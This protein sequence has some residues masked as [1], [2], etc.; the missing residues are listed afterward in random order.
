MAY[1]QALDSQVGGHV[2]VMTTED[3][4]LLIK[5]A[6]RRE[7]EFYH[8]MHQDP[9]LSFLREFTPKFIG[10]LRLEGQLSDLAGENGEGGL[11]IASLSEGIIRPAEGPKDMCSLC[12]GYSSVSV[13]TL[14]IYSRL[15]L[16]IFRIRSG[17]RIF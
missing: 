14:D 5:P 16:R 13:L 7:L 9:K 8:A 3:G 15:Y 12:F 10:V 4:S 17:S 6:L 1:T 11:S 2:G